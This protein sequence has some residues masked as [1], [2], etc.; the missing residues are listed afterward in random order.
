MA[1]SLSRNR[2]YGLLWSS[3]ALSGAGFS[4]TVIA[5]PLL[6]LAITHSPAVSGLVLGVIAA[7]Q[8]VA[9][10]PAGALADRWDRKKIMLYCE[11]GQAVAVT[12]L[13]A[14]LWWDAVTVPHLVAVGAVLGA[15]KAL[16][17]PAE[18]A[19]LPRLVAT[20]QLATALAMNSARANLGQLAGTAVGGFLYAAGRAVPFVADAISHAAAFVAL[21]FV[22]LPPSPPRIGPPSHLGREIAAGLR[23]TW[24]HPHVRITMWCAVTLN[25]FF[26]AYFVVI[27]VLL[28]QAGVPSG[29]LG[30]MA[31]MLG[32]GGIAGAL[33]APR[34][35]RLLSPYLSIMVVFWALTA[36]TPVALLIHNGYLMGV[37]FAAIALLPPTASTTI[38]TYQLL[39]TPD[40]LR[41]RLS[42]VMA[43]AAGVSGAVGPVLG[44]ALMQLVPGGR[45]VLV[46]TG[47]IALITLLFTLS[48]TLRSFPRPDAPQPD[49]PSPDGEPVA[50][51]TPDTAA[52]SG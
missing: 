3:Q 24:R 37:L 19:C 11:A 17:G 27:I 29:Q 16:F 21:S 28:Q 30:V 8:L 20:E 15:S 13:V 52:E 46:C 31:A 5:F 41:G 23:W 42:G 4:A 10:L 12:S 14:A 45:A 25:L 34:L 2:D 49:T 43:V 9:G 47:G 48:A 6:V 26:S 1:V 32:V 50:V 36:L 40:E 18:A 22:R 39:L 51:E 38:N 44:G 33:I 7:A 35:H